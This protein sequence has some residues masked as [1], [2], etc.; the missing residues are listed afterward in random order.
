MVKMFTFDFTKTKIWSQQKAA[1]KFIQNRQRWRL[2][3]VHVHC[4]S[5]KILCGALYIPT[6]GDLNINGWCDTAN[7]L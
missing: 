3:D 5:D 7:E 4:T 6:E 1:V 2:C